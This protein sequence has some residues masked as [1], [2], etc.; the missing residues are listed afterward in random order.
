MHTLAQILHRRPLVSAAPDESVLDVARRMTDAS[1]GAI[2]VLREGRIA[3]IFSERDLMTRVVVAGRD[4]AAT[5][6]HEVMTREVVTAQLGDRTG[7]C[8]EK[9]SRAGCRHLPVLSAG[10]VVAMLSMRDLLQDDLQ[11]QLAENQ[12]LRAYLH[13]VP[14]LPRTEA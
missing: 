7:E 11:A 13:Q 10:R 2:V 9:M 1:V 5:R 4:P 8:E 14:V 3:G 6:V 12:E